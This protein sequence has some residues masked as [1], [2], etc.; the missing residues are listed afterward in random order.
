MI[1]FRKYVNVHFY[2]HGTP[3][4]D[5]SGK[6]IFCIFHVNDPLIKANFLIT[7]GKEATAVS[8]RC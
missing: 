5:A 4:I 7:R 3:A 6:N 8:A 1:L 2:S